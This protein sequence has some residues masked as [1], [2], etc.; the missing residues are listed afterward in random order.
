VEVGATMEY[1]AVT[2]FRNNK[3]GFSIIEILIVITIIAILIGILLPNLNE[4]R[5]KARDAKRK[6]DIRSIAQALESYKNN[7]SLPVYPDSSSAFPAPGQPWTSGGVTYMTMPTDPLY[8]SNGT[9]YFYRYYSNPAVD[10][11]KYYLGACLEDAN[12]PE[13]ENNPPAGTGWSNCATM[14]WYVK[15]EP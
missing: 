12:D 4:A 15:S 6:A 13:K 11:A 10:A 14:S 9:Q 5:L 1:Q 3:K 2:L 7:Q 8:A